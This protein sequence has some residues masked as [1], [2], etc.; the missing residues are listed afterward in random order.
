MLKD[1]GG[2]CREEK[3]LVME[4]VDVRVSNSRVVR[5]VGSSPTK[6]T[7]AQVTLERCFNER[8][9]KR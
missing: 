1:S 8:G 9:V 5:R 7:R 6:G 4:L 3:A 2:K